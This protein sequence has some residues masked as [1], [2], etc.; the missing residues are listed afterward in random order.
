MTKL[1][2]LNTALIMSPTVEGFPI[3][4]MSPPIERPPVF[5][6]SPISCLQ[7]YLSIEPCWLKR[8]IICVPTILYTL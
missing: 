5:L 2:T 7:T 8:F 1:I 3:I 4:L 6:M